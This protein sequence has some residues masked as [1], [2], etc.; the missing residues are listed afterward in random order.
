MVTLEMLLWLGLGI[1]LGGVAGYVWA[2]TRVG[3]TRD[4]LQKERDALIKEVESLRQQ[5]LDLR[6]EEERLQSELRAAEEK[7]Q[8]LGQA[9]EALEATFKA[10]AGDA[11]RDNAAQL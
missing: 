6:L 10:L 9:K 7:V 5:T 4:L 8:W 11:L 3:R 1:F 2:V